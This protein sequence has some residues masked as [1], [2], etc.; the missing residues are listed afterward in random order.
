MYMLL[1]FYSKKKNEWFPSCYTFYDL[2]YFLDNINIFCVYSI[3]LERRREKGK[4]EN[5]KEI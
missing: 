3:A 2:N 4:L 5:R 1:R